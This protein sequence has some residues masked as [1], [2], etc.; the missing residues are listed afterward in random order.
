[1]ISDTNKKRR[2]TEEEATMCLGADEWV[3]R[4]VAARAGGGGLER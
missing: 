3:R 2:A 1:V 4:R